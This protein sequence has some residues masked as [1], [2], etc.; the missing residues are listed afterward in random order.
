M[1]DIMD[2]L[3]LS[4]PF[5]KVDQ[6][7][8]VV[9]GIATADNIDPAGDII[10]FDASKEAFEN[11]TGNIREMHQPEAV[12]K[13]LTYRPVKVPYNGKIYDGIEVEAYI[14]KGAENTWEKVLDGTLRGFSVGGKTLKKDVSQ[15]KHS[16]RQG[17]GIKKYK[18]HE[19]SLV[20]NPGNPAAQISLI[21]RAEDGSL[22]YALQKYDV[23]YC[24]KDEVASVDNVVCNTCSGEMDLVGSVEN[25]DSDIIRKFVSSI[26]A[27]RIQIQEENMAELLNKTNDDNVSS[28]E[29]TK[30]Q[31]DGIL[32]KFAKNLFGSGSEEATLV[33][34]TVAPAPVINI[35]NTPAEIQKSADEVV[36]EETEEVTE[37]SDVEKSADEITKEGNEMDLDI[38][39]AALGELLDEKLTVVKD[40]IQ[41]S[42]DEK[43]EGIQKSVD[44]AKEET[45]SALSE[46][47]DK[48]EKVEESGAFKKSIDAT[49]ETDE[50]DLE[51]S[52]GGFWDGVWVHPELVKALGYES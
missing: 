9:T 37:V 31:Q 41:A 16:G 11:W 43:I 4:F 22:E 46:V 29:L 5:T 7:R 26:L 48:V 36:T 14:S 24:E 25:T 49:D 34:A 52:E 45:A 51:K 10:D 40:E 23:Y 28:M 32:A 20:D 18:L 13:A 8:R 44:E 50:S 39:K 2:D 27:E 3:T 30:E 19:L 42:V 17:T 21:K 15:D 38:L 47:S 1:V 6:A 33:E 12:G 35:Y